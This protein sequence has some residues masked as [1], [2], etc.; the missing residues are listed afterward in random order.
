MSAS[1][2]SMSA[3]EAL[4]STLHPAMSVLDAF[5]ALMPKQLMSTSLLSMS[6]F[7]ALWLDKPLQMS[8]LHL[9]CS[10]GDDAFC[11]HVHEP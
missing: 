11:T 4:M 9:R 7:D 6:A 10:A 1:L 2:L 3:V 5:W 8:T